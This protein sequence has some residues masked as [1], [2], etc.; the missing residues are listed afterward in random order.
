MA[1]LLC[2]EGNPAEAERVVRRGLETDDTAPEGFVILGE[3]LRLLNRLD[4]AEKS[5]HEALVRSPNYPGAYLILANVAEH[6]GDYR[7][8]SQDLDVYL[9]LQ[10]NG[11]G[12]AL[13]R[14]A[15]ENALQKLAKA[16]PQD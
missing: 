14:R 2:Q 10:P 4:D 11:P 8:E 3:A 6:R 15:R 5:A 9:K 16:D 13:A 12:S 1:Y 7:S